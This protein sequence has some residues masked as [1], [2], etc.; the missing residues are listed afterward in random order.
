LSRRSPPSNKNGKAIA[1]PKLQTLARVHGRDMDRLTLFLC[2][3]V[4]TGRGIDQVLPH[5]SNP[6]LYE[7]HV[8]SAVEYVVMAERTNGPIP[9][10]VDFDYVWGDAAA[11]LDR[12]APA[13]RI[14]NLETSITTSEDYGRKGINY[15]MHPANTPCLTAARIDC[16]VLAN[17]HVLDWG[18]SG[19]TETLTSLHAAGIKTAGA[20]NNLKE[21]LQPAILNAG[22]HSRIL[23]IAAGMAD[24]GIPPQW[25]ATEVGPGIVWLPSLSTEIADCV[26]EQLQ[27][28]RRPGDLI[29]F[30][31]HWGGNWGYKVT[32]AQRLF[33]H[34]LIDLGAVDVIHGHSSHHP[35][36]IEVYRNKPIL[37]GCGDFLNDY[38]GIGGYEEFRSHLVLMYFVTL[39]PRTGNVLRLKM[40]PLEIR[41][42]RLQRAGSRDA[43]WLR[44]VLTREG[45]TRVIVDND[46]RLELK[47]Q[48]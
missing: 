16:C 37:Y 14:I 43:L 18:F 34:R 29:V 30:S 22:D 7:P 20:G 32:Q 11:E 4:M 45:G 8:Q 35:K 40:T 1:D 25:A 39:D 21:A 24:S 12:I 41:R 15:R 26:V 10:H 13:A 38:E 42:F 23:V 46:G 3:D 2:G 44:D 5:P 33:A 28:L 19:L 36:A 27:T 9:R 6:V 31:I 48:L 47:W 17:N